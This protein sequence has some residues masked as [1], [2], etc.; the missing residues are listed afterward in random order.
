LCK[1]SSVTI[2][3]VFRAL[4]REPVTEKEVK[5]YLASRSR[6]QIDSFEEVPLSYRR[7]I[8]ARR[9]Q[10][11]ARTIPHIHLFAE[12]IVDEL[13]R[14]KAELI[15]SGTRITLTDLFLR[16]LG[17][18]LFEF[19]SF[20]ATY[21]EQKGEP[22]LRKY[23]Q[24]NIGLAVSTAHGLVVPVLRDVSNKP[25]DRIVREKVELIARARDNRLSPEDL[26]GA[27]FTL[28]N[29]GNFQVTHF[30]ALINPPQVAILSIG[31]AS[32]R[33]QP[34]KGRPQRVRVAAICLGLDHRALDGTDGARFISRFKELVEASTGD[35][36]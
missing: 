19:P 12:V 30:T 4:A 7:K 35:S 3:E 28:S 15:R 33:F 16:H 5:E 18:V 1:R 20:N 27:T 9:M 11:S 23:R 22:A 6:P 24:V 8:I 26:A 21:V 32:E 31:R 25:L 2:E 10:D 13:E 36:A 14:Q 29:L 17:Q 34:V